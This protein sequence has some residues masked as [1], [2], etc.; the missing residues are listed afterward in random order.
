M[1]GVVRMAKFLFSAGEVM[2]GRVGANLKGIDLAQG[3]D[4]LRAVARSRAASRTWAARPAARCRRATPRK[5]TEDVGRIVLGAELAHRL[6]AQRR[7]TAC[8]SWCRSAPA[9]RDTPPSFLFKVVGLFR[10]G[11]NEY[12]TRLAYVSL[13]DAQRLANARRLGVRRRAALRR[14][15]HGAGAGQRGASAA[16]TPPTGSSTGRS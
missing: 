3:A 2:V 12:D 10:M 7:A 9:T 4:D 8:R 5:T 11:F 14:P 16:W 13:A 15:D 6:H 1:P